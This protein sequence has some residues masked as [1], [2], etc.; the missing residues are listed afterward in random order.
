MGL[1]RI[2]R[3]PLVTLYG[4]WEGDNI[5]ELEGAF[6]DWTFEAN[7]DGTLHARN[8]TGEFD[9]P[10]LPVGCWFSA[11]AVYS[12]NPATTVSYLQEV[13]TTAPVIYTLETE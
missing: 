8:D 9:A 12:G 5:A 4:S 3:R 2:T 13:T 6:P 10:D 1:K 11:D 7:Q